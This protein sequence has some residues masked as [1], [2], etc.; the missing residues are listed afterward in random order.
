MKIHI[1]NP[2]HDIALAAGTPLF[3]APR[4]GRQLRSDMGFL[5]AL[6][7]ADGDVVVVDDIHCLDSY[8]P[9]FR[10]LFANVEFVSWPQLS[11]MDVTDAEVDVWGWDAVICR[12]LVRANPAFAP[13]LPGDEQLE[14]IRR[15]SNRR[16]A[17]EN[18][19]PRLLEIDERL[20]GQAEY[21]DD[22]DAVADRLALGSWVLKSPW[23][24][25]GRG[26]RFFDKPLTA[27]EKGWCRNVIEQQGGIMLESKYNNVCDFA[28]EFVSDGRGG[29]DYRGLSVFT[30]DGGGYTGNLVAD[31]KEKEEIL[32]EHVEAG[33]VYRIRDK[34]ADV[35]SASVGRDYRG[36]FGVDMMIVEEAEG[37]AEKIVPCVELNLRRTMGHVALALAEKGKVPVPSLMNITYSGGRYFLNF[38]F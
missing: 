7:A 38:T 22:I 15:M 1:F 20:T 28:M 36:V 34:I 8:S 4:A 24:S 32:S 17:A 9:M 30:T 3:T 13:L 25:S 31:E 27:Q 29:I 14:N 33:L 2:D 16:F 37:R 18:L 10:E 11:R 26:V 5:P 12:E 35:L 23:S 19:L 21:I 6:W